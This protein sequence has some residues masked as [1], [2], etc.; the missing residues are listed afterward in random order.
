MPDDSDAYDPDPE[1]V[2]DAANSRRHER[3]EIVED[4]MGRVGNLLQEQKYPVTSEELA[5][6]YADETI[7]LKNETESLGSVFDRL[8]DERFESV[9]EA[10]EAVANEL[11]GEEGGPAEFNDERSLSGMEED[12]ERL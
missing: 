9:A 1:R 12:E 10:R 2:Q 6:E 8:T 11:T 3:T 4:T 7:D 5:I